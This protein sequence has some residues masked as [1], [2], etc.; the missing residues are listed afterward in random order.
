MGVALAAGNLLGG[1]IGVRLT[2]LRGHVW[3]KRVV[4]IAVIAFAIRLWWG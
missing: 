3:V 1:L 2:V 4:T